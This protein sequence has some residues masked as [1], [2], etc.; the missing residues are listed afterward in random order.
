MNFILGFILLVNGASE[1]EAFWMFKILA[2][3]PDFM[4]MG[5]F[6]DSLPLLRFL[7]YLSMTVL[8]DNHS[9]FLDFLVQEEIEES[10]WLTKWFMTMFLYNFP[11]KICARF[12]DYIITSSVFGIIS[13]IDGLLFVFKKHFMKGN[14]FDFLESFSQITQ[15]EK[16]LTNPKDPLF[17]NFADVVKNAD[18]CN[19]KK[20]RIAKLAT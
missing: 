4:W 17:L 6:E 19:I 18:K 2:E 13:L 16:K 11:A 20:S 12:W 14:S 1:S 8:R 7:E 5:L 9:D 15:D 10:F 3:H